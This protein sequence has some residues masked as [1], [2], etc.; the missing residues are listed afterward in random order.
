MRKGSPIMGKMILLMVALAVLVVPRTQADERASQTSPAPDKAIAPANTTG[1]RTIS[2]K[3]LEQA[4]P[5]FRNQFMPRHPAPYRVSKSPGHYSSADWARAIDST[6]GPGLSWSQHYYIW[7]RFWTTVNNRFACFPGLETTIWDDVRNLYDPEVLDTVSRGRLCGITTHACRRLRESHT[8]TFDSVVEFTELKPGVPLLVVGAFGV[9]DHFGAGL[10]VL[11]DSSLLVYKAVPSHPLGLVAGDIVLGYDGIAWKDIVPELIAAELPIT[12]WWIGSSDIS[13][14][15]N[16]LVSAGMN[17]HLFDTIDVVKYSSGDTVHLATQI[18]DGQNMSLWAT[19]QMDIPGVSMPDYSSGDLTSWGIISG[20]NV[21][22][23]YSLG[24]LRGVADSAATINEWLTAIDSLQYQY[25]VS[26]VILDFRTNYGTSFSFAKA[27]GRFFDTTMTPLGMKIRCGDHFSLCP[28][29]NFDWYFAIKGDSTSYWDRPIAI[30]TGPGE[31]SGGDIYP[32]LLSMHPM[33]KVFGRPTT[34]AFNGM[35]YYTLASGWSQGISNLSMY[36][37]S[38]PDHFITRDTFPGGATFPWVDYQP[39]WLS[40]DGVAQGRD[41]VVEAAKE[42]ILSRDLDQDG[43]VNEND[44]C[45]DIANAN[46]ADADN[47]GFGDLCDNCTDTDADAFGNPGYVANTCIVD[48]CPNVSNPTQADANHDGIG[49]ACCCVG[50]RGNVNYT[51]IVDLG[52]L[53]ALVSYL[54]GGGYAL[55]CPNEA[56]VNGTGIV[57]LSDLSALVSYL[58]GGAYVLP[59]CS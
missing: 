32:M 3:L 42:W 48:N 51:G 56:N 6:W 11:P 30:L 5:E 57:D 24:W 36:L 46:Q 27:L 37:A 33:A 16:F 29:T 19:E 9:N 7:D 40:P 47:D 58:T 35:G 52:D 1:P 4:P 49:D 21:G 28:Y 55:P 20:T 53:S 34:G 23:I 18:L 26:G 8:M 10:T 38:N 12:G 44:N 45:P 41:D 50:V 22:Y 15:Y 31:Y 43:V 17:W 59:N 39:V 2:K 25:N 13:Y 54:T 14:K